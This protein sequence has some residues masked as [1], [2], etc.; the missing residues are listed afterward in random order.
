MEAHVRQGCLGKGVQK[1]VQQGWGSE[2]GRR[3]TKAGVRSKGGSVQQRQASAS[4]EQQLQ[5]EGLA[6][7]KLDASP[8]VS[9]WQ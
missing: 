6:G 4:L 5:D 1:G 7:K 9:P 3:T 8:P 2:Q